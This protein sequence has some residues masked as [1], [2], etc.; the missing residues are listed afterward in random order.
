MSKTTTTRHN[1]G[2]IPR[3]G[4]AV[5]M[6]YRVQQ[7]CTYFKVS[8]RSFKISAAPRCGATLASPTSARR[9]PRGFATKRGAGVARTRLH[10]ATEAFCERARGWRR[11]SQTAKNKAWSQPQPISESVAEGSPSSLNAQPSSRRQRP[12][13]CASIGGTKKSFQRRPYAG[14]RWMNSDRTF[15]R[16]PFGGF[17]ALESTGSRVRGS[18]TLWPSSKNSARMVASSQLSRTDSHCKGR[19]LR[20]FW[21][22]SPG[23][24]KWSV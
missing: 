13:E 1:S 19:G 18:E 6:L 14:P 10:G 8:L 7:N 22:C 9:C 17:F 23:P 3:R 21:L 4:R 2:Q 20:L 16:G 24:P 5:R 12:A 15:D 11:H